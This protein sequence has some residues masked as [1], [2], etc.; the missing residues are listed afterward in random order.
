MFSKL[1]SPPTDAA[2]TKKLGAM[3]T[4]FTGEY[5]QMLFPGTG[6]AK[7]VD[8]E[9]GIKLDPKPVTELD[10][11]SYVINK[12]SEN[13]AAPKNAVKLVPAGKL[14]MNEGF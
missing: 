9:M 11:V 7:V 8:H 4:L 6:A 2:T 12:I 10:R 14:E 5:D 1:P 3:N 13:V